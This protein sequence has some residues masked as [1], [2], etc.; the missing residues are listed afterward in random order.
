METEFITK[1]ALSSLPGL[2]SAV[3]ILVQFTKGFFKNKASTNFIRFYVLLVS[4]ILTYFF[5]YFGE[6][7]QGILLIFINSIVVAVGAIG[8]FEIISDNPENLE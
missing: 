5:A 1:E 3:T 7:V 6:G 4:F 8:T 2:I